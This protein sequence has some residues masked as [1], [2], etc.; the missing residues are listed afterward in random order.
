MRLEASPDAHR[1][2]NLVEDDGIEPSLSAYQTGVLPL[3]ESSFLLENARGFASRGGREYTRSG[4]HGKG[5]TCGFL[6]VREAL[7]PLSYTP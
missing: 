1:S 6:F 3:D 4:R 2:K 5:R 7:I